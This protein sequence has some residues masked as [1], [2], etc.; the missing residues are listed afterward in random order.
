MSGGHF[1]YQQYRIN[2][3]ACEVDRLIATNADQTKNDFGDTIGRNYT[4][5]T[6]AEFQKAVIALRI[7]EEYVQ[8]IDWLVSGDD[9]EETF[10][11]RLKEGLRKINEGC[12]ET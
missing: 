1:E 10:H 11:Q 9:G 2:D 4:P 3:L 8:R 5:E 6:I 12:Y 7:S